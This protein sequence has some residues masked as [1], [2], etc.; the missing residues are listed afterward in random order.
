M[1]QV[2]RNGNELKLSNKT[3]IFVH[4]TDPR[5]RLAMDKLLL[6]LSL[7]MLLMSMTVNTAPVSESKLLSTIDLRQKQF[8][9]SSED[10][11]SGDDDD[12]SIQAENAESN[13]MKKVNKISNQRNAQ[14]ENADGDADDNDQRRGPFIRR[15]DELLG[16]TGLRQNKMIGFHPFNAVPFGYSAFAAPVFYPPEFYDDFAAYFSGYGDDDEIMS[17]MNP[18]GNRR[19]PAAGSYKNSPI[20]YIRLPPTPYMFVPGLGYISQPPS[21]APMTPVPQPISPF[22]NL[23]LEFLSNGKPTNI[24]QWGSPASQFAPQSQFV[25]PQFDPYP[26]YHQRPQRP[27][28]SQRPLSPVNPFVEESKV[29]N[30][31]GPYLFNGRPEE[32]FLL[33]NS[34]NPI[35]S[36]PRFTA[37]YF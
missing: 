8:S 37:A 26:S 10:N 3:R 35:Y 34:F 32:I 6:S 14:D 18:G 27:H 25:Q 16:E 17:R 33:R 36:D 29:T 7:C 20:Y 11:G 28:Y 23:P 19:R 5:K 13:Q 4:S 12:D 21:F 24:Y 22:Y 30:L 2:Y 31:K 15:R 9:H 1:Q